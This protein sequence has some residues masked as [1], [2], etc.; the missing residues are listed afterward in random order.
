MNIDEKLQSSKYLRIIPRSEDFAIYH[1]L[2]GGL[3]IIDKKILKLFELLN[4]PKSLNEVM[5]YT[6]EYSVD[7]IESFIN[8]FKPRH[9]LVNPDFDEYDLI[10]QRI[11][12]RKKHLQS[13]QQ[14]GIIQLVVTNLCNFR[15]K[16]CFINS[17]YSVLI[18]YPNSIFK[19]PSA[20][21]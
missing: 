1:S 16:Y 13:G 21:I 20:L 10:K 11:D 8:L 12:S 5:L 4:S 17:I 2:F 18:S 6:N 3:C 14:I 7:F 19:S 15:C 9:F